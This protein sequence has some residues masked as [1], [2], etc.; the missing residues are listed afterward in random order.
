MCV[1]NKGSK[2]YFLTVMHYAGGRRRKASFPTS[3]G[4]AHVHM[5]NWMTTEISCKG[6]I[7]LQGHQLSCWMLCSWHNWIL[8]W[9]IAPTWTLMFL[10]LFFSDV[11]DPVEVCWVKTRGTLMMKKLLW[12]ARLW[13]RS[14]EKPQQCHPTEPSSD[15]Y[16]GQE[17]NKPES[18]TRLW[19]GMN[20]WVM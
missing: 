6:P 12:P 2:P 20:L 8:L 3:A 7:S 15:L 11:F 5:Q 4:H 1:F 19:V 10:L 18:Q 17:F 14:W 13:G 16:R 9:S